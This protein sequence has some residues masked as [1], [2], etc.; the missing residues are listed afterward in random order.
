[1]YLLILRRSMT[2]GVALLARAAAASMASVASLVEV[3]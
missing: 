1:M 2:F 3:V